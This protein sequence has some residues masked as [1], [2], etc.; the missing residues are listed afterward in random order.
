MVAQPLSPLA[1]ATLSPLSTATLSPLTRSPTRCAAVR[2][3]ASTSTT[4]PSCG[5]QLSAK[6]TK[7]HLAFCSPDL[8]DPVGWASGDQRYIL[9][10]ARKSKHRKALELRFG[11]DTSVRSTT[12]LAARLGWSQ[13][14]ARDAI[15][16][17][18]HSVPPPPERAPLDILFEDELIVAV[19]KPAGVPV[20]PPH[21]LR[22]GS[23]LN[24]LVA[25]LGAPPHPCHR[26]DLSTS[27]VLLF[28]KNERAAAALM[29]DFEARRVRKTYAALCAGA[30][31]ASPERR[32]NVV[33]I[34]APICRVDGE[35]ER[36][37]RRVCG[38]GETGQPARTKLAALAA[39][40]AACAVLATP[41]QGRT[42]QVRLHCAHAGTPI[43]GDDLYAGAGAR[44]IASDAGLERLALH[45]FGLRIAHPAT[46]APLELA[47]PLP[48]DLV[49]AAAA[50]GL[51]PL[52]GVADGAPPAVGRLLASLR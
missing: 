33:K 36:C 4:C 37:V 19:D 23:V 28:A 26:L 30:A 31:P 40:A 6:N 8:L 29:G 10:A 15:S 1:T 42:H 44:A 51:T 14:R 41:Q 9:Q 48:N 13:R 27:G 25:H 47:A 38:A 2:C 24:R 39:S 52:P 20:T 18:L 35:D 49:A 5:A 43:L 50:L 21:R 17:F 45:A 46:G 7:R 32:G 3:S 22:T 34:E 12:E 16:S 11:D